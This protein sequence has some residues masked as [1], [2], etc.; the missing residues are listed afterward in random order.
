M[1][2]HAIIMAGGSGTRLWPL[3]RGGS[4]KQALKLAGERT[5]F[6]NAV[7]RLLP[8]FSIDRIAIV[9]REEHRAILSAQMPDMPSNNFICEPEGRGT[10]PAIGLAAI[11][12]RRKNPDA[13]MAVL[14]A[15]HFIANAEQF[16]KTLTAAFQV[17][18]KGRLV[19]LGITPSSASTGFGYIKQADLLEGTGNIP[20]FRV[21]KFVE[22][23]DAEN[24]SRM[25][26]SKDYCWN[27][28][29]FIWKV[30]RILEEFKHLMPEFYEQLLKVEKAIGTSSYNS[31]INRIWPEVTKETIDYGIMEKSKDV[32]VI[33]VDIGWTDIGNWSSLYDL[34]PHDDCGNAVRGPHIGIDTNDTL[35]LGNGK[36]LI[37]T[38]GLK[39]MVIVDTDDAVLICPKNR[40]QE[41]RGIVKKLG[42]KHMREWL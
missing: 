32:A 21:E 23:P 12:L 38:I 24:A 1:N 39:D 28:G 19:T 3:S 26:E 5:M 25:F 36:R 9:T 2:Y 18:A 29:M 22:K 11:H 30:E 41:V 20:V 16:R 35:V 40:E 6:Q 34:I 10:A 37:A 8:L 17:A 27:S 33:P 31:T 13:V 42:E 15:D 14:T 7:D 4:P